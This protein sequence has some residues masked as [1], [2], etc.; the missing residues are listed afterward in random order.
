MKKMPTET[1]RL[2]PTGDTPPLPTYDLSWWDHEPG[3]KLFPDGLNSDPSLFFHGTV[4]TREELIDRDGLLPHVGG[5]ALEQARAVVGCFEILGW[6]G[7]RVSGYP[8]LRSYA[9]KNDFRDGDRSP[10]YLSDRSSQAN[11]FAGPARAGG[12][13]LSACRVALADLERLAQE[14]HVPKTNRKCPGFPDPS[15]FQLN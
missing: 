7:S 10:L 5:V 12:E 15:R 13:K 6:L 2:K 11:H 1:D 4:S 9:L 8:V 3:A 14:E